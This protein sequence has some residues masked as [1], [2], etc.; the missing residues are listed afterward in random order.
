MAAFFGAGFS[1]SELEPESEDSAFLA[2]FFG[3][4]FSDSLELPESELD[5]FLATFFSFLATTLTDSELESESESELDS[6]LVFFC[7]TT[8]FSVVFLALF[9]LAL[10][11]A[12]T[13]EAAL[14]LFGAGLASDE[15]E[16]ESEEDDDDST[17][18][19][20]FLVSLT[21]AAT[22]F[23]S[24]TFFSLFLST[25]TFLGGASDDELSESELLDETTG[26]FCFYKE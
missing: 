6:T 13:P 5:S 8:A 2:A 19:L 15:S 12:E 26:F 3:A 22:F 24:S 14:D 25:L 9:E 17:F 4:G 10:L 20:D 21:G 23:F 11:A 18:F 7:G 16:S 1:E